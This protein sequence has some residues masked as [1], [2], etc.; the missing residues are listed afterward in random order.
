MATL[1]CSAFS[2]TTTKTTI[3]EEQDEEAPDI[4][5]NLKKKTRKTRELCQVKQAHALF[6]NMCMGVC[7]LKLFKISLQ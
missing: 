4:E 1:I 2:T 5:E 6:R 7:C 3:Q